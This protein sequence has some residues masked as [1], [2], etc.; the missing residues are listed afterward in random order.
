M[1]KK[2][3]IDINEDGSKP[4]TLK[5]IKQ[6]FSSMPNDIE[7]TDNEREIITDLQN[8]DTIQEIANLNIKFNG[9]LC[10]GYTITDLEQ[11]ITV[12]C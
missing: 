9:G 11:N 12:H 2:Y 5:E 4:M 6:F 1:E 8:A 3:Y 7:L 10:S